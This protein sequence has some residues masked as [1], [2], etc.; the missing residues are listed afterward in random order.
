M[1]N[2][3]T[4]MTNGCFDV[5]HVG[6]ILH[7]QEAAK[8]GDRFVVAINSDESVKKLKGEGRP[9]FSQN[10]RIIMLLALECVDDVYVF[11][12]DEPKSFIE[13]LTPDVLVKGE[14]HADYVSGGDH[15]IA[16]GGEVILLP[17]HS[18]YS[19]TDIIER[20]KS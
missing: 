14:D 20:M 13:A 1:S 18:G 7:L 16:N 6:H 4:V 9:I 15:V 12:G 2:Q 8:L 3:K 17:L 11:Y 19:T 5:L 10:E